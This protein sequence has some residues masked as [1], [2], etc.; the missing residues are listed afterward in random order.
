VEDFHNMKEHA[1]P[2]PELAED[3]ILNGVREALRQLPERAVTEALSTA[4]PDVIR[5]AVTSRGDVF[6]RN[7]IVVLSAAGGPS[8]RIP[9]NDL[10]ATIGRGD[11]SA[12]RL[13]GRGVSQLHCTLERDGLFVRIRDL[14]SKNHVYINR[15]PVT[16]EQLREGD[17]VRLG[18]VTLVVRRE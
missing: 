17:E 14:D 13:D 18:V 7:D 8:L 4:C 5:Q 6:G 15:C 11:Q 16:V 10:P 3:S 1:N 12:Y 9:V 2:G